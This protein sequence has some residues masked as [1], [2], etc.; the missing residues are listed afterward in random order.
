MSYLGLGP[1][2]P[3][4]S[5]GRMLS[6]E[7]QNFFRSAPWLG[8]FPGL[9]LALAVF[10]LNLFGDSLRDHLDPKLRS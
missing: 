5:W 10:S 2:P 9:A 3:L 1:P 8:I 6:D 7:G 4:P